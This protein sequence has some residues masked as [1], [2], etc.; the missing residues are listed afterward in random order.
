[1]ARISGEAN[2]LHKLLKKLRNKSLYKLKKKNH[3]IQIMIIVFRLC[4]NKSDNKVINKLKLSKSKLN[5][6]RKFLMMFRNNN[7]M[8]KKK[9]FKHILII[10]QHIKNKM[11]LQ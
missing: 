4:L 5:K 6:L 2:L 3:Q 7:K 11:I 10:L 1:M 8:M 9:K